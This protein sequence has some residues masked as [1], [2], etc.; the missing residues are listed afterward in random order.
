V[1]QPSRLMILPLALAAACGT[2]SPD[3]P[4]PTEITGVISRDATWSGALDLRGFVTIDPGVTV[5]VE[6]GTTIRVATAA[7]IEVDG[8]LA[9]AGTKDHPVTIT[10]AEAGEHWLGITVAGTFTMQYATQ[11]GGGLYTIGA[12]ASVTVS[13]SQLSNAIGDFL[14]V[15]GGS[16][17]IQYSNIGLEVG[18]STHC[19]VHITAAS[20]I[21]FS[22]NNNVGVSYGLMLYGG[23]GDF[24]HNNWIGNLFDIEPQAAGTGNFDDSYFARGIPAGVPGSTFGH[25][26]AARLADCGPR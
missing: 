9:V 23:A 16:F 15:E 25:P 3:D 20:R 14:I 2:D 1:T 5:T 6:P 13:D 26:S 8:T 21:K 11:R 7:A 18:D 4:A 22:H 24:S 19:N 10:P 17:D 12:A